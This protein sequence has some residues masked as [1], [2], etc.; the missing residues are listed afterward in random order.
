MLSKIGKSNFSFT[1]NLSRNLNKHENFS[2]TIGEL[3]GALDSTLQLEFK[4]RIIRSNPLEN[5]KLSNNLPQT[6]FDNIYD[7]LK[8][9]M[10]EENSKIVKFEV[11][12]DNHT[13]TQSDPRKNDIILHN[14]KNEA[15]GDNNQEVREQIYPGEGRINEGSNSRKKEVKHV[16]FRL[17]VPTSDQLDKPELTKMMDQLPIIFGMDSNSSPQLE[18]QQNVNSMKTLKEFSFECRFFS[19][20]NKNDISVGDIP[21]ENE[22]SQPKSQNT[23]NK[24]PIVNPFNHQTDEN[25]PVQNVSMFDPDEGNSKIKHSQ[26]SSLQFDEIKNEKRREEISTP[27]KFSKSREKSFTSHHFITINTDSKH[28]YMKEN[29]RKVLHIADEIANEDIL[30]N[31]PNKRKISVSNRSNKN[32][33]MSSIKEVKR[34]SDN[35]DQIDFNLRKAKRGVIKSMNFENSD[36]NISVENINRASNKSSSFDSRANPGFLMGVNEQPKLPTPRFQRSDYYSRIFCSEDFL[37]ELSM[38]NVSPQR[39]LSRPIVKV[40]GKFLIN[41]RSCNPEEV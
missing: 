1:K 32:E 33:N 10:K 5:N 21:H 35:L 38:K 26:K 25:E 22:E 28:N 40:K 6:S 34:T 20:E 39:P 24:S 14:D 16:H 41:P 36:C 2:K 9:F 15:G 8:S 27:K 23:Q 4:N 19:Q 31:L 13:E 3:K 18:K 11:P 17:D 29:A 37:S 7:S 12:P 30:K